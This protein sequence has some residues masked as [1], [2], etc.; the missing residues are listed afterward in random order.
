MLD[1]KTRKRLI[2]IL[3]TVLVTLLLITI[4]IASIPSIL[5]STFAG[6]FFNIDEVSRDILEIDES[7]PDIVEDMEKVAIYQ[8]TIIIID[9]LN[10]EWIE[11][12]K[13]ENHDCDEFEINYDYTLTWESLISIDSVLLKQDFENVD[14]EEVIKLGLKFITRGVGFETREIEEEYEVENEDDT[15]SIETQIVTIKVGIITIGTK[16]F[17]DVLPEVKIIDEEDI[18]LATNIFETISFIDLEENFNIYDSPIDLSDL[19]EYPPGNA[20]IPYYNQTDKRWGADF[21][22]SSPI[23]NSGCGPTSL[24]MVVSGLTGQQITPNEVAQWSVANGHRAEGAGSYWSLMTAGGSYY[25]LNVESVSRNNPDKIVE[26]LS[27]GHPVVASMGKGH[28]TNGGHFIV[29]R[30]LTAD[31]KILVHDSNS[32]KRSNQEWDLSIIM[33]ESSTNGGV[34]GN[35]FWIFK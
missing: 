17:N 26:A 25:G 20:D 35:P 18:L 31:G 22:G 15:I 10:K 32:V 1:E 13:A 24:A 16:E 14:P 23:A 33:N 12:T 2:T 5:I 28:F 4:T 34:S 6:H 3:T 27:N 30:G 21:Y 29:L 9:E 19:K 8:D 11:E 7:D